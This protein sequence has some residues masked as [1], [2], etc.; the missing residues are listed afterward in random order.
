VA[1][2]E[3]LLNPGMFI[4]IWG[5]MVPFP[6]AKC[7]GRTQSW[8]MIELKPFTDMVELKTWYT[9]LNVGKVCSHL[10]FCKNRF[11]FRLYLHSNSNGRTATEKGEMEEGGVL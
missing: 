11:L 5:S 1:M 6:P 2:T 4:F 8:D 3:L 10:N 7:T 9:G